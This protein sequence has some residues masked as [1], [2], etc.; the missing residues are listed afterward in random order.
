LVVESPLCSIGNARRFDEGLR[1]VVGVTV[2][3]VPHHSK[4]YRLLR[5]DA[6][7]TAGDHPRFVAIHRLVALAHGELDALN[8]PLDVHHL[9]KLR[10]RNGPENLEALP[11]EDHGRVTR[12]QE[13]YGP[14]EVGESPEALNHRGAATNGGNHA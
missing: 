11:S 4:G 9:D 14:A 10:D 13:Q 5:V 8:Q 7:D 3:L 1:T 12:E 2:R 6:E